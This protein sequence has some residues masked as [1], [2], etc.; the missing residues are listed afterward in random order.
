[1]EN[2]KERVL[3]CNGKYALVNKVAGEICS[4][5]QNKNEEFFYLPA[6]FSSWFLTEYPDLDPSEFQCVNR[7]DRPVSGV[8]I[9]ALTSD[10]NTAL[11]KMVKKHLQMEKEY[12]AVVEGVH[13]RT[14]DWIHLEQFL[15][16][17]AKVQKA[18]VEKTAGN[19]ALPAVLE[20]RVVGN[21]T[22]YSFVTVKLITGRTHQI[23]C[24]LASLGLRIKGDLKYGAKRSEKNGGIRLHAACLSFP[25]PFTGKMVSVTAP[26]PYSDPL[27]DA[28]TESYKVNL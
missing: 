15:S 21:G 16:Y 25:D 17:N 11:S 23:R 26:L 10:A 27:W 13:E 9:I 6:V 19:G 14:D 7:I 22:K 28:F 3:F 18:H 12:W 2:A 24:Q 1:M 5:P 20:Y 4:Q 8:V